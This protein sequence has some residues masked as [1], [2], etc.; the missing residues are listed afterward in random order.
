[1]VLNGKTILISGVGP[2]LGGSCAA[3]AL[4]DG[5]NVIATARNLE[6]L[7]AAMAELDPSGGARSRSV[8]TSWI[9]VR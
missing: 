7:E 4:R 3:A 5:A 2:G 9:V 8:P 6:R 1:M